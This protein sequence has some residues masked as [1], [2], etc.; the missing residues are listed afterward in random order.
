M[1][2]VESIQLTAS[3]YATAA[4]VW[5]PIT[6]LES[7]KQWTSALAEGLSFEGAWDTGSKIRFLSPGV[8]CTLPAT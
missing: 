7:Y 5:H 4:V 8:V 6:S 3:I 1:S 2:T